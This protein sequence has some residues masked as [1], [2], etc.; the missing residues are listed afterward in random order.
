MVGNLLNNEP[1]RSWSQWPCG[2]RRG[3]AAAWLLGSRV[4]ISLRTWM[5]V[6]FVF[7]R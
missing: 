1:E 5:I 4:R 6:C 3:S 7:C 2:L